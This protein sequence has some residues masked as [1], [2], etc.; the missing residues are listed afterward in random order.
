MSAPTSEGWRAM[1][2]ADV[3]GMIEVGAAP[4]SWGFTPDRFHRFSYLWRKD[5]AVLWSFIA[6]LEHGRGY[7]SHLRATIEAD[8]LAVVV[9]TPFPKMRAILMRWGFEQTWER[10]EESGED[11]ELWRRPQPLPAPPTPNGDEK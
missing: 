10:D 9:P 2:S 1:E 3:A 8:G 5:G 7:L 11:V 6:T 4:E